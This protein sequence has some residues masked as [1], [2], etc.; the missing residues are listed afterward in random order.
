MRLT[1]FL[2]SGGSM[3][4]QHSSH[5]QNRMLSPAEQAQRTPPLL[6]DLVSAERNN[7]ESFQSKHMQKK[8]SPLEGGD[9]GSITFVKRIRSHTESPAQSRLI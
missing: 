9:A 5:P 7:S 8:T 3:L 2:H 6:A 1:Q 4:L